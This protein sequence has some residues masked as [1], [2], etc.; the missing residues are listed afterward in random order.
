MKKQKL[1][2][3]F[4][5]AKLFTAILIFFIIPDLQAQ[6]YTVIP[7]ET[8]VIEWQ[9]RGYVFEGFT[10]ERSQEALGG[11]FVTNTQV[12]S[13]HLESEIGE[14]M[15]RITPS[16]QKSGQN[17]VVYG[18][19]MELSVEE[20]VLSSNVV[21]GRI[22]LSYAFEQLKNDSFS[23]L[24]DYQGGVTYKR[25]THRTDLIGSAL[26]KALAAG[27]RHFHEWMEDEMQINPS[28]STE[29]LISIENYEEVEVGDTVFYH[30]ERPLTWDD[31]KDRPNSGSRFAASIFPSFSIDGDSEV[32]DGKLILNMRLKVFMLKNASWVAGDSKNTYG[33][34][35]EQ[36]HFDLVKI[37][38]ERFRQ[39]LLTMDLDPEDYDSEINFEYLEAFREMN[40]LQAAYDEATAHGR[41]KQAQAEWDKLI[42]EVLETQNWHLVDQLLR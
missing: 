42:D 39:M 33:L 4:P 13:G 28:F 34:N 41:N 1:K 22:N 3:L 7:I 15:S 10:D 17:N 29:L 38:G 35:H 16:P 32:V 19:V 12:R 6:Q 40:R 37:V 25:S 23:H 8:P 11:V 26:G 18:R 14:I 20:K 2:A 21:E 30:A 24:L 31:F 36:R 27:L 9:P 5:I